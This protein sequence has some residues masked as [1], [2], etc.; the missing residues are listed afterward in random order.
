MWIY[1]A[2]KWKYIRENEAT[3]KFFLFFSG[4]GNRVLNLFDANHYQI[5]DE[6]RYRAETQFYAK[7]G[8][9]EEKIDSSTQ[10]QTTNN[11]NSDWKTLDN[12][13]QNVINNQ[14]IWID[15]SGHEINNPE[16]QI[17]N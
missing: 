13:Q 2:T 17:N 1:Q 12:N 7:V 16:N 8:K 4:I 9:K 6:E 10:N 3:N 15:L 11:T 5:V 14:N